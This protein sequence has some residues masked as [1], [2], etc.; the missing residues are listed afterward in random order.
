MDANGFLRLNMVQKVILN[1]INQTS[2]QKL[3]QK[4]DIDYRKTFSVVSKKVSFRIIMA[5]VTRYDLKLHQL[6]VKTTFLNRN[7]EEK[8]YM[9]QL[10]D[11]SI[12]GKEHKVCKLKKSIYKLKQAFLQWYLKFNYTVISFGFQENIID[13]CR[14]VKI[15]GGK[16]IFLIMYIDDM[17]FVV[18]KDKFNLMQCLKNELE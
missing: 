13:Q 8:V 6:D 2:C 9:D 10:E 15:S 1:D 18:K 3:T 12:K 16:F 14:Y 7:L 11:F 4:E 5:L 17:L